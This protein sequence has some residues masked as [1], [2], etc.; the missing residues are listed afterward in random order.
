MVMSEGQYHGLSD[1]SLEVIAEPV[2]DGVRVQVS[3]DMDL[4]TAPEVGRVLRSAE[5]AEPASITLDLSGVE[6]LDS[7][8]VGVLVD[9]AVRARDNGH[10]LRIVPSRPVDQMIDLCGIR[11]HMPLEPGAP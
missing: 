11:E 7:R 4:H 10:R 5:E 3:G 9:A 2:E 6:F 1:G 8:G